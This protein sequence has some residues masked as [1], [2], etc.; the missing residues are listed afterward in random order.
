M[1][2]QRDEV[3]T[4]TGNRNTY[5]KSRTLLLEGLAGYFPI[6]I[7]N[8]RKSVLDGA[9]ISAR[10]NYF[11]VLIERNV[12]GNLILIYFFSKLRM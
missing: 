8:V 1:V 9:R 2:P 5:R 4:I 12:V 7:T 3:L 6:I 11:I 10:Y